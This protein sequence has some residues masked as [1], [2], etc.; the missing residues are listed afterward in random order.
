MNNDR[1]NFLKQVFA[2]TVCTAVCP[3]I[4]LGKL[5]P[6][7]IDKGDK[8]SGIYTVKISQ[9]PVLNDLWGSVR[10]EVIGI[11]PIIHYPKIIVTRVPKEDYVYDFTCVTE[12]C[13]H[14]GNP[15][16]LLNPLTLRFECKKGHGSLYDPDGTYFSGVSKKNLPSYKLD[17]TSGDNIYIVIDALTTGVIDNSDA[18]LLFLSQNYPNP[19][20]GNTLI[21]YGIEKS[22]YTE[23]SLF[24]LS[25]NK[26]KEIFKGYVNSGLYE[27]NFDTSVLSSGT[28]FYKLISNNNPPIIRK[29]KVI[30]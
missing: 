17:Y 8:I 13:P 22:E 14:E 2:A 12:Q 3:H 27:L 23:I 15:V 21:R 1:R 20:S 9:F 30:R 6:K 25:G 19:C 11:D 24:D 29:M 5:T 10:M 7:I 26:I 18:S 16:E 28:Y 4:I